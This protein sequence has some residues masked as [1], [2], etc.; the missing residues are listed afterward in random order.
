MT[1]THEWANDTPFTKQPTQVKMNY[2]TRQPAWVAYD[3]KVLRF[4]GYFKE[5]ITERREENHRVRRCVV[6]YY[7][8]D[9][10]MSIDEPRE[11]NSGIPQGAFLRR[12]RVPKSDGSFVGLHDFVV[13]GQLE[14]YARTF[15][16]LACDPFTRT[17]LQKSGIEVGPDQEYPYATPHH[18]FRRDFSRRVQAA[19]DSNTHFWAG[20]SLKSLE[21]DKKVLRF[22]AC[23]D[24]RGSLFGDRHA[25]I[26]HYY[27]SDDTV[28][29]LEVHARNSGR[30]PFPKL[31][32]RMKLPKHVYEVGACPMS[33][34]SRAKL[35]Y[36][37]YHFTELK[38]GGT[39]EVYNRKLLLHDCDEFTKSFYITYCNR[40][41]E[42]FAPIKIADSELTRPKVK[43][44]PHEGFGSEYDSLQSCLHLIPKPAKRDTMRFIEQEGKVMRFNAKMVD[45]PALAIRLNS[46]EKSRKFV[47]SYFIVDD[48]IQVFEPPVRNS[49]IVGGKFFERGPVNKRDGKK[50][51]ARDMFIGARVSVFGRSFELL[52]ADEY[53]LEFMESNHWSFPKSDAVRIVENTVEALA[54]QYP[55][56]N[57]ALNAL[58]TALLAH[59]YNGNSS[60]EIEELMPALNEVCPGALSTQQEAITLC[61]AFGVGRVD[62]TREAS[63]LSIG[64]MVEQVKRAITRTLGPVDSSAAT[65]APQTGASDLTMED[66]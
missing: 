26:V 4:F 8:E 54:R 20:P 65:Q 41:P 58:Q 3:R 31:L 42:D 43:F 59:D 36:K 49:G 32:N 10:S 56:S 39:V 63:S 6:C 34:E 29:V 1:L 19:G 7:L 28:E 13:G 23:W 14:V 46:V 40:T 35:N 60:V 44:P 48:T 51:L 64:A 30:D 38:I 33:A 47:I 2:T 9:G 18:Q 57:S 52:D 50:Y 15:F 66:M 55:D 11:D 61:R 53:T 37:Y 45:D 16:L 12:H 17:F 25:Y 27:L 24:D 22:Y 5:A 62:H 21:L